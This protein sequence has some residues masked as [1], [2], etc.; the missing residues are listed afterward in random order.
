LFHFI[1]RPCYRFWHQYLIRLGFLDGREGFI[2]A[3]TSAFAV[4]KRYL[5]L[6]TKYRNID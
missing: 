6:W 4:F 3:Y 5:Y 2:L 1:V